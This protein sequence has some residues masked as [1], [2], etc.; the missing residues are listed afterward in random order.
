[1]RTPSIGYTDRVNFPIWVFWNRIFT[2]F[3]Q[4]NAQCQF[5][6]RRLSLN[7][8]DTDAWVTTVI[9]ET[10]FW[11]KITILVVKM[12]WIK[13]KIEDSLFLDIFDRIWGV[14]QRVGWW[15]TGADQLL[16]APYWELI[17]IPSSE[18]GW[19]RCHVTRHGASHR[20]RLVSNGGQL[21]IFV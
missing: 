7:M 8:T 6:N 18:P 1:M 15:L 20:W 4:I 3:S 21:M 14:W 5:W 12:S 10:I 13:Y 9:R 11:H 17:N 16:L 2:A 19:A